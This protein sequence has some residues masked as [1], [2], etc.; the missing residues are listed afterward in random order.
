MLSRFLLLV[1]IAA[2]AEV[3][4]QEI[5]VKYR[6]DRVDLKHF[7]CTKTISS[8]VNEV[9][10]DR[11]NQYMIIQLRDARYPYCDIDA[12]TVSALLSA[13]SKG[14]YYNASIK[15]RFGCQGKAQPRY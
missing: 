9:C 1:I 15:G 12:Q 7:A 4:A 10:Y 13:D 11:Q 14:R 5:D 6:E 3:S 8:F 2:A